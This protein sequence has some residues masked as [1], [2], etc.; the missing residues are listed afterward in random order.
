MKQ[1][2]TLF[3]LLLS[4]G[5]AAQTVNVTQDITTNTTWTNNNIYILF[6]DIFVKNGATL[7]IQPGT[8]IRGDRTTLSRLVVTTSGTIDAQGTPDQP[9]VFTSN[10]AAGS[11]ARADWAGIAIL[12]TAPINTRDAGGNSIQ[13]RLECGTSTDYDFG[14]SDPNDNS[15]VFRYVRIEYAGYVCGSNTELNSLTLGGVGA[16]TTI[17][18]VMVS[19]GQD[20]GFELFGGTVNLNNIVSYALRDDD[21]DTD[22]GWSGDISHALIVRLDTIADQGDVSNGFES[23]NDPNGTS[24][25]PLTSG[26][27]SNVTIIGPAETT[28]SVIDPKYGWIARLRR[29]TSQSIFNSLFIGY[30]RGLRIE[31]TGAQT[32]AS[33]GALEFKNNL[34]GGTKEAYGETAFDTALLINPVNFNRIYGGN[35]ND[36]ARLRNP[37]AMGNMR[38]F[39]PQAGSPALSG[40]NFSYPKLS[41]FTT[42]TYVGAFGEFPIQ[43]NDW[44]NGWTS[45]D[46]QNEIYTSAPLNYGYTASLNITGGTASGSMR[47]ICPGET[48]TLEA[49]SSASGATFEWSTGATTS[50][51]NLTT[52]GNYWVIVRDSRGSRK[53][54]S[55]SIGLYPAPAQPTITPSASS[56][57]TG[58]SVVLTSSNANGYS[59]NFNGQNTSSITITSGGA[60]SVTTSDANGCRAA[61]TI[62]ITENAPISPVITASAST[63]FCTGDSITL[64]ASNAASFSGFNWLGGSSTSDSLIVTATGNYSLI[65]TDLNGCTDTSNIITTSVSATPS[66]TISASGPLIFCQGGSVVI[67]S[68]AADSYLWSTGDSTRS[69]TVS[70]SGNITVTV[71]NSNQCLG[72]G[73][74]NQLSVNAV[75]VPAAA[76]SNNTLSAPYIYEFS[77]NSTGATSFSWNFGNGQSS[78][79]QN[80]DSVIFTQNGQFTITLIA[81]NSSGNV[82]CADTAVSTITVIGVGIEEITNTADNI[83]LYPNPAHDHIRLSFDLSHQTEAAIQISDLQGRAI[84]NFLMD[85]QGGN[86]LLSIETSELAAGLY[87]LQL[88]VAAQRKTFRFSIQH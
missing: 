77:N 67:T 19:Y 71:T 39:R 14:G 66:P 28:G 73:A 36:T 88:D 62:T 31:G 1:I 81:R 5:A 84:R 82:V 44:A 68:S 83:Q 51:I 69:I 33:S 32:N 8:I 20:D 12:G 7:T 57:C 2:L 58:S 79:Q 64:R 21:I 9:I 60:Y 3:A 40:S 76:F 53:T 11:R 27:V 74:S 25:T 80:P 86:N 85:A 55:Q 4:L 17:D 52:A 59:W 45:F 54:L 38:D 6:G 22:D 50:S 35:A 43:S 18:H 48:V 37:Y 42:T 78:T 63:S 15:G 61:D 46:P 75:D 70:S 49:I 16:G 41:G 23:D 30:K 65:G 24:N 56:I 10:Q 29:N 13:K 72:V 26:V 34:I 47:M 87:L